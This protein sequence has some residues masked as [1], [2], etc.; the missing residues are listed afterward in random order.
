MKI[1]IGLYFIYAIV[2]CFVLGDN[3]IYPN[4][5]ICSLPSEEDK[6]FL[7]KLIVNKFETCDGKINITNFNIYYSCD[8]CNL[9]DM[10]KGYINFDSFLSYQLSINGE[11]GKCVNYVGPENY[12]SNPFFI[13]IRISDHVESNSENNRI[14]SGDEKIG[15]I[16]LISID[17]I[18]I[19]PQDYRKCIVRYVD[20]VLFWEAKVF[21]LYDLDI[22]FHKGEEMGRRTIFNRRVEIKIRNRISI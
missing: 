21:V 14:L 20:G 5:E 11:S 13:K 18:R 9:S 17:N 6:R 15:N 4:A 3:K 16:S 7:K 8:D 10:S 22:L 12:L 19:D 2:L 1:F